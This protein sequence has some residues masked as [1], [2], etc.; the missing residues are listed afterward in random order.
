MEG[1]C[2]MKSFE[3]CN[4]IKE[5]MMGE[6]RSTHEKDDKFIKNV[7]RKPEDKSPLGRRM[8]RSED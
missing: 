7:A 6:G 8:R 2:I 3:T 1:M 5:D 4:N